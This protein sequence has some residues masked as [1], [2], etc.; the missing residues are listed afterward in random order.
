MTN[1]LGRNQQWLSVLMPLFRYTFEAMYHVD[2]D[3]LTSASFA[4]V[5]ST[6]PTLRF[7]DSQ[8]RAVPAA[9]R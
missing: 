1:R 7:G 3:Q 6:R 5:T 9:K 8:Q 2:A 4:T